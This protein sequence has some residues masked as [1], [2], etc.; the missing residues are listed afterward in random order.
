MQR[1]DDNSLTELFPLESIPD[2]GARQAVIDGPEGPLAVFVVRRGEVVRAYV[3]SCPHLGVALNWKPDAF[4][5][6]AGNSIVCA[7]HAAVFRIDDG[8]CEAGPCKGRSL[9]RLDV[10]FRNGNLAVGGA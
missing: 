9:R 10:G 4:L 3:N 1:P 8:L 6:P 7:M 2:P 5:D